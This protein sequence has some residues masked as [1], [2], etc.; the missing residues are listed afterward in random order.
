MEKN[1]LNKNARGGS[2]LMQERLYGSIPL[3]L[4]DKFQ[5]ILSRVRDINPDKK[6]I[7]WLHDHHEDPEIQH[8]K[9]LSSRSRFD[10]IVCVS[11]WQMY[12]YNA[13]LGL[14]YENAIVLKN[15]IEP[16]PITTKEYD[17]TVNIIYHTTPH[18]GL[19][20]LVPVFEELCKKYDN[21]HLHVYSS[22]KVYG[23][24]EADKQFEELFNRCRS[25]P[26]ITYHGAVTNEEV[27]DAL[28]KSHIYAYPSIW[29]E[30]SCL[31][32]IEAMSA[33]NLVVCPNFAVLPETCSNFAMMYQWQEDVNKHATIFAQT[34]DTAIRTIIKNQGN[35]DPY[36]DFQKQYFDHFYGWETRKAEWLTLLNQLDATLQ[37]QP[38]NPNVFVYKT[39]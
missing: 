21:I 16:I 4:L 3:E 17:G 36:L 34:L 1:E 5:I 30:T 38:V 20:I 23:W 32:V 11:N 22:F 37:V 29:P 12:S 18:R 2:E 19:G 35:T 39:S 33:K 27:R 7:L 9:D 25:H 28:T 26:K 13:Y 14:P 24:E 6:K 10:K 31:S 15:A 8:L